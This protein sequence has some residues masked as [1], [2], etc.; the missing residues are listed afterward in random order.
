[1]TLD[2]TVLEPP[3]EVPSAPPAIALDAAF[4]GE[5]DRIDVPQDPGHPTAEEA[6]DAVLAFLWEVAADDP[7][8]PADPPPSTA[9]SGDTHPYPGRRPW[10]CVICP[11]AFGC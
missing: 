4:G 7:S 5:V 8:E 10:Y 6:A 2:G 9:D 3:A 1:M 11:G